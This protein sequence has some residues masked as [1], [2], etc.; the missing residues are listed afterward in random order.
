MFFY[1][2]LRAIKKQ[3]GSERHIKELLIQ[4]AKLRRAIEFVKYVYKI[5]C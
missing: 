4:S 1:T 2:F 5:C 3:I